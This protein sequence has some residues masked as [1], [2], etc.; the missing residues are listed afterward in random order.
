MFY[1]YVLLALE[2]I[3]II[4]AIK[5]GHGIG[6]VLFILFFPLIGCIVYFSIVIVPELRES[7]AYSGAGSSLMRKI[8]PKR[9]LRRRMEALQV[10]DSVTNRARL[11]EECLSQGMYDDAIRL[12]QESMSGVFQDDP[13]LL[14]G[15][16]KAYGY[17]GRYEEAKAMLERLGDRVEGRAAV[18]ARLLYAMVHE[19]TG[20]AD[21][22]LREY[23]ALI[24]GFTGPEAKC[25]YGLLLEKIGEKEKAQ[26]VFQDIVTTAR[27][28]PGFYRKLHRKWIDIAK[29]H[30]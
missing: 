18:D 23:E 28:S 27:R 16:A 2:V 9:N 1:W 19:A 21:A 12:Y 29:K 14:L 17:G 7:R 26:A 3:F 25:R 11:A 6:W 22:A 5:R 13:D 8:D 10:T 30:S 15:L 20:D 24:P 4:H